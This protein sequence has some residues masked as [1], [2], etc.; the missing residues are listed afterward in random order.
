ML[1]ANRLGLC[2]V[3]SGSGLRIG[4]VWGPRRPAWP[5]GREQ[6]MNPD[7]KQESPELV[8]NEVQ[9]L[10]AEKRTS[11]ASMRTGIAVFALPL[12]VLSVLIATSG[13]YDIV[14]VM[15]FLVPLL[16]ICSALVLLGCFLII[17]AIIR[18][19][20]NDYL[21]L[22]IKREHSVISEFID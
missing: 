5:Q 13:F 18:I 19:R 17:Q 10:L 2:E 12:S 8:W 15:H 1:K 3:D 20:H 6:K 7:E 22:K 9:L 14:H 4:T 11:L 21:I 16:I